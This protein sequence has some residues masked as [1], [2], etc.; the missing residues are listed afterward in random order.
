MG[1]SHDKWE[2]YVRRRVPEPKHAHV[3]RVLM[4]FD[5]APTADGGHTAFMVMACDC[6]QLDLMPFDNFALTTPEFQ[7]WLRQRVA[8][9]GYGWHT[10][11]AM[12]GHAPAGE[13]RL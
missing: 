6:R 9:L 5:R 13:V 12:A 1:W 3:Y 7:V 2:R 11:Q 10:V 8:D 4:E